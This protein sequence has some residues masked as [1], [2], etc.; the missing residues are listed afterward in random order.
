M[1]RALL[2][3]LGLLAVAGCGESTQLPD[4]NLVVRGDQA[5]P[6]PTSPDQTPGPGRGLRIAAARIA[7]VSHGQASTDATSSVTAWSVTIRGRGTSWFLT[8]ERGC[9]P[10]GDVHFGDRNDR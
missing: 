8:P 3:L 5:V 9:E 1:R 2:V 7:V 10:Q 6:T 4:E